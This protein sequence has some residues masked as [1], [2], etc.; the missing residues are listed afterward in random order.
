MNEKELFISFLK[1]NRIYRRFLKNCDGPINKFCIDPILFVT[2]AFVFYETKEGHYYWANINRK[3][4]A[5]LKKK[6][7]EK[8]G[9]IH[10]GLSG[11]KG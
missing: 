11:A 10:R 3:W 2:G 9:N 8:K 6:Q 1:K 7:D 4:L 5:Y